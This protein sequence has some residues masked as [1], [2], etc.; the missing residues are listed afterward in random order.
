M[1]H[2]HCLTSPLS[3]L[4]CHH[5]HC[6]S[7]PPTPSPPPPPVTTTVS[8][9]QMMPLGIIWAYGIFYFLFT[10]FFCLLIRYPRPHSTSTITSTIPIAQT[11]QKH[12]LSYLVSFFFFFFPLFSHLLIHYCHQEQYVE[13]T[14]GRY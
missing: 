1:S 5:H 8:T 12:C 11:M 4:P 7:P 6:P 3:S 13:K 2:H 9:A 10:L 14:A